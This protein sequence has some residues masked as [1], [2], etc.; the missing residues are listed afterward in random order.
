VFIYA[1]L[2]GMKG[3]TYT[4][5]AQYIVL[6]I[7]YTIPA[8]FISMQLTGNPFLPQMGLFEHA[9]RIRSAAADQAEPSADGAGLQ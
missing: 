6:I 4:Q 1:V 5:L 7:A 9:Y 2:G 3:I 8:V